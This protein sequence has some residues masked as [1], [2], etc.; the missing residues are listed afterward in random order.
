MFTHFKVWQTITR[1]IV[2]KKLSQYSYQFFSANRNRLCAICFTQLS[3]PQVT[4][5]AA[6]L[7]WTY[8]ISLWY[9]DKGYFMFKWLVL[10]KH[11]FCS[12]VMF[13]FLNHRSSENELW[14]VCLEI[15]L[16]IKIRD[17]TIVLTVTLRQK[18][19]YWVISCL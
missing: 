8:E 15:K 12:S 1:E 4:I 7:L 17:E 19:F 10:Q 9:S 11:L 2:W 16:I 3:S 6:F 5:E 14:M 13:H 18:H